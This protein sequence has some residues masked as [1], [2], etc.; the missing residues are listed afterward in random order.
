MKK[1][2]VLLVFLLPALMIYA[3]KIKVKNGNIGN[4]KG[5]DEYNVVFDYSNVVIPGYD[6]EEL[7]LKD[8]M[9]KREEKLIGD[10]ER[11]KKSWFDDRHNLY[12]PYFIKHFNE[13]FIMKRKIN[14]EKN[15]V[16]SKYT[17]LVKTGLIYP[18][19]NIGVFAQNSKLEATISI[20]ETGSPGNI[21]FSTKTIFVQGKASYNGG[22]RIANTYGI[23]GRAFAGYLRRRT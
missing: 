15:R 10:G 20:Y 23:L 8:K 12:E 14:V 2:L 4:L 6:T 22:V 3:Q 7:F 17:M 13:Y 1:Q 9:A 11:F 18:G 21:L 16:S 19:Y 5:V